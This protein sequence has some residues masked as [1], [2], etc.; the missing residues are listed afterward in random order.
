MFTDFRQ[1]PASIEERDEYLSRELDEAKARQFE[2]MEHLLEAIARNES[3][4]ADWLAF[5]DAQVDTKAAQMV[6]DQFRF[7]V[8]ADRENAR[9]LAG[10]AS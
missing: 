8:A 7:A 5:R 4:T 3:M 1:E 6:F 10:E 9:F 2:L